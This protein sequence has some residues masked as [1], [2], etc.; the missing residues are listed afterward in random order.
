MTVALTISASAL[1]G[2]TVS[3]NATGTFA[4][5]GKADVT[6]AVVWFTDNSKVTVSNSSPTNG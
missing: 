4:G 6:D 1:T 2:Q 5:G 3:F